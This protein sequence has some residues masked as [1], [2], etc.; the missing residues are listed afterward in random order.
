MNYLQVV[1]IQSTIWNVLKDLS[2][3]IH[4]DKQDSFRFLKAIKQGNQS[5]K[6]GHMA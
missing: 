6:Y 5:E 1:T 4:N 2:H 3:L